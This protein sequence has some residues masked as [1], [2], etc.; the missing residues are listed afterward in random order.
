M[1]VYRY[2][3]YDL[4]TNL[5]KDEL[6]LNGVVF[7]N[8]LNNAGSFQGNI[9]TRHPKALPETLDPGRTAIFVERDGGIVWGGILWR[10]QVQ[11][12]TEKSTI[13]LA[14]N[15]FFSY[16]LD[17]SNR[18]R[19]IRHTKVYTEDDQLFI[20]R[21]LIDYAQEIT[22]GVSANIGVT[23]GSELTTDEGGIAQLR[24]RT[25]NFYERKNIGDAIRDLAALENGFEFVIDCFYDAG[26]ISKVFRLHY[27]IIHETPPIIFDYPNNIL[28]YTLPVD[29]TKMAKKVDA[30]GAGEGDSTLIATVEDTS[31]E[32]YPQREGTFSYK[33]ISVAATLEA[34][35]LG[36][37]NRVKSPP[38]IP[39]LLC[40][41]QPPEFGP[42]ALRVGANIRAHID[43]GFVQLNGPYRV[44]QT[45]VRVDDDGSEM[46]TVRLNGEDV[47][48]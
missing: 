1:A 48:A 13:S 21:D 37:L 30:I 24:T 29:A 10:L 34:R 40:S 44:A 38:T 22:H 14:G 7:S 35:A 25:Y 16:F 6:P 46:M 43:D 36:D 23:T 42:G 15:D 41:L 17:V 2:L 28:S 3:F 8:V 4:L 9:S 20:A 5:P 26:T 12:G 18:G 39:T 45:E 32:Q 47:L 19:Y 27:P 11:T 31:L 33:D